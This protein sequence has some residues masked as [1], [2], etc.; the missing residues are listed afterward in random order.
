MARRRSRENPDMT[1]LLILGGVAAAGVAGYFVWQAS[2]PSMPNQGPTEVG[3]EVSVT[4]S[5]GSNPTATLSMAS[6]NTLAVFPPAGGVA[7]SMSV[8]GNL[9]APV[10]NTTTTATA[11][12]SGTVTYSWTDSSNN[13]QTATIPV[14][15]NA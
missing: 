2:Q 10:S 11:V 12:G 1:M 15:I 9:S 6:Q 4:A 13:T 14:T 8:S 3:G 7:S 5:T